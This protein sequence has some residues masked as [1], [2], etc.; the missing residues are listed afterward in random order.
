MSS[1]IQR[2][3]S[4]SCSAAFNCFV[5]SSSAAGAFQ[6][7]KPET[8]IYHNDKF[9]WADDRTLKDDV[10]SCHYITDFQVAI[11]VRT[12]MNEL[13]CH[14]PITRQ[15][16]SGFSSMFTCRARN[17]FKVPIGTNPGLT[18]NNTYCTVVALYIKLG[19]EP[20]GPNL[21]CP[22]N[23]KTNLPCSLSFIQQVLLCNV[24][25]YSNSS[26]VLFLAKRF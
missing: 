24:K 2:F 16:C 6:N 15:F 21:Y 25:I 7:M 26:L 10:F 13:N 3:F 1:T 12:H 11:K 22:Y 20:A 19:F 5:I 18:L 4:N 14:V 9:Y 23:F 8:D 17:L